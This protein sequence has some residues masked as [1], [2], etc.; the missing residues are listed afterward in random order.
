VKLT[1]PLLF[2]PLIDISLLKLKT[3]KQNEH[4]TVNFMCNPQTISYSTLKTTL[5][6]PQQ[7]W[8]VNK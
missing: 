6:L 3:N 1:T 8:L 4:S 7:W 2:D 5:I